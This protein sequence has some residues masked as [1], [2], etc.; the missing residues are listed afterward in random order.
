[1]ENRRQ[2]RIERTVDHHKVIDEGIAT[3]KQDSGQPHHSGLPKLTIELVPASAWYSNMRKLVKRSVWDQI[4]KE[5]YAAYDHRCGICGADTRLECHEIWE[6][7]DV[8]HIQRLTGLIALC[9]LCHFVKH[10]GLAGIL[11]SEGRLDLEVVVA[12]YMTINKCDREAYQTHK[13]IAFREWRER[14]EHEWQVDLGTFSE[15]FGLTQATGK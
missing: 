9:K 3:N 5:V 10:L 12:H 6:Y 7:D 14:S 2:Q 11:A 4:R 15:Q 13:T 1:V 8:R